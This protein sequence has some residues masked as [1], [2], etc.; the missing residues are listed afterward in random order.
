[1]RAVRPG[2]RASFS[3]SPENFFSFMPPGKTFFFLPAPASRSSS[4][5]GRQTGIEPRRVKITVPAFEPL[6]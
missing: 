5:G 3:D 4:C 6:T 1:M 2:I